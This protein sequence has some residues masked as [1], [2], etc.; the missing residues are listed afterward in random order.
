TEGV[1][2]ALEELRPD[3]PIAFS[4]HGTGEEDAVRMVRE[5]LSMQPYDRMDDAVK[6]AVRAAAV[7]AAADRG[8]GRREAV[9]GG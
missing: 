3:V 4:I 9:T 7:R 6:A 5:R 2:K 1:V 8:P